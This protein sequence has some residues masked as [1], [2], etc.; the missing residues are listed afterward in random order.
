MKPKA[1]T[2]DVTV[3]LHKL[4]PLGTAELSRVSYLLESMASVPVKHTP[5]E[6]CRMAEYLRDM[7]E[8]AL[9]DLGIDSAKEDNVHPD[10]DWDK[11]WKV[12]KL[13]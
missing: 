10:K 4:C 12:L 3:D 5:E 13:K 8:D 7:L 11:M 2:I 9:C 1:A 6:V